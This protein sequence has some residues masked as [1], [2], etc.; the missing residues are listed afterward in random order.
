MKLSNF[1]TIFN[2]EKNTKKP[3]R[4]ASFFLHASLEKKK[5]IFQEAARKA[6][7]DQREVVH[8]P[9]LKLKTR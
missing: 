6:N 4:F 7:E 1:F 8:Q 2:R 3:G 9:G 5:E